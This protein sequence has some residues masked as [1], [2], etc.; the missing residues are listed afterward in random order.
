MMP[1]VHRKWSI[2]AENIDSILQTRWIA[3]GEL[4]MHNMHNDSCLSFS[5]SLFATYQERLVIRQISDVDYVQVNS[6]NSCLMTSY[7][8]FQMYYL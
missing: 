3:N 6:N 2:F 4:D 8:H 5:S 1:F 7:E